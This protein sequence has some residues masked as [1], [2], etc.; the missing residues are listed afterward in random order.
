[1]VFIFN[2]WSLSLSVITVE[3]I[4]GTQGHEENRLFYLWKSAGTP[5]KAT[6]RKDPRDSEIQRNPTL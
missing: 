4:Q 1:G 6:V 3:G 2:C 5:P